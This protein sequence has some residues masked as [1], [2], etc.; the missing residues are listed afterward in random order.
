MN[1]VL[2]N[3]LTTEEA[4]CELEAESE[5]YTGLYVDMNNKPERKYVKDKAELISGI[6]KNLDRA[7]IDKTKGFKLKVDSE[8]AA[9]KERLL[10]ANKPFQDLI[11]EYKKERAE[12]LSKEKAIR[13]AKELAEQIPIDHNEAIEMN[14]LFDFRRLEAVKAQA[15]REKA[16]MASAAEE[17]RVSAIREQER[18]EA[19]V[20]IDRLKRE[21]DR[22]HLASVNNGILRALVDNGIEE[23]AAKTV[24]TLAAKGLLPNLTINY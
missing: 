22:A 13:E 6:L 3:D 15:D 23:S 14:E 2:F 17:A 9:I 19:Q 24:I 16:L 20:E 7:R 8:A 18:K 12:V 1:I 4:L 11:D 21:S 5:K 10:S